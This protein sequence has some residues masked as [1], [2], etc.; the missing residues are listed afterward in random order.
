M[1]GG[2]DQAIQDLLRSDLPE[3]FDAT[4]PADPLVAVSFTEDLFELSP[5][6]AE[7]AAT[8]PRPDDRLDRL[9]FDPNNP[10]GPYLLTQTPLPGPRR[11]RLA[12]PLGDSL[13]LTSAEYEFDFAE[14]RSFTLS[15][16]PHRDLAS[17]NGVHVIYSVTAVYV[18]LKYNQ[19]LSLILTSADPA[20]L[21]RAE[22]LAVAL[23][24]LRRDPLVA[25]ANASFSSGDYGAAITVKTLHLRTGT[26]PSATSRRLQFRAEM[27]LKG[28]RSLAE[29][30]DRPIVR[31]RSTIGP[32]NPD[33]PVD[34]NIDVEA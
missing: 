1:I 27:E 31:I 22:A 6:S 28:T 29:T 12:T 7:P 14:P 33:K 5:D 34:I 23:V 26:A 25:A 24:S 13:A 16:K 32:P 30:E 20:A 15:P 4:A 8:E 2:L 11:V 19:D 21:E 17:F 9:A 18:Q 3:L 10:A